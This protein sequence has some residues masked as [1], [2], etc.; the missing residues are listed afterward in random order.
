M[1]WTGPV[2]S[3]VYA[4]GPYLLGPDSP[5]GTDVVRVTTIAAGAGIVV[6]ALGIGIVRLAQRRRRN[7]LKRWLR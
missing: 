2:L 5:Q 1:S 7:R 4:L 6:V 3:A